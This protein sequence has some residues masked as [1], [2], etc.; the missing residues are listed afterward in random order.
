MG[1]K[2]RSCVLSEEAEELRKGL[3]RD[4]AELREVLEKNM[5]FGLSKPRRVSAYGPS[6][7]PLTTNALPKSAQNIPTP[8][9]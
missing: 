7:T 2:L 1:V 3:Q 6:P 5:F 4:I 8:F 9:V